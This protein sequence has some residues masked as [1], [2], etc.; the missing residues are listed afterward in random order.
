[1]TSTS[2]TNPTVHTANETLSGFPAIRHTSSLTLSEQLAL[3]DALCDWRVQL[4]GRITPKQYNE[5]VIR[6]VRVVADPG[7]SV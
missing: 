3:R 6:H 2:L 5:L 4:V 1:M 7:S